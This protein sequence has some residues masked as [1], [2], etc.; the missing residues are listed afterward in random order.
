M[1]RSGAANK[2]KT[3]QPSLRELRVTF[4][5]EKLNINVTKTT[6]AL[7]RPLIHVRYFEAVLCA[8]TDNFIWLYV[9]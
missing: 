6:C 1:S 4:A 8:L 2:T 3:W 9:Y 5:K 7:F